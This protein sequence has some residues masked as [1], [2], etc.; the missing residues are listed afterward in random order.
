MDF[1]C[2]RFMNVEKMFIPNHGPRA[3][4]HHSPQNEL[5]FFYLCILIGFFILRCM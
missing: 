4:I 5:T 3:P 2:V 1:F